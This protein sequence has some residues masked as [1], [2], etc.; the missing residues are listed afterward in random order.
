MSVSYLLL[1][2]F[3]DF[4]VLVGLQQGKYQ[5]SSLVG[6]SFL[7]FFS[8]VQ[9]VPESEQVFGDGFGVFVGRRGPLVYLDEFPPGAPRVDIDSCPFGVELDLGP[10]PGRQEMFQIILLLHHDILNFLAVDFQRQF[11]LKL[12]PLG[13]FHHILDLSGL[14]QGLLCVRYFLGVLLEIV[15]L[16]D[17]FYLSDRF[18]VLYGV[19]LMHLPTALQQVWQP[20]G[21]EVLVALVPEFQRT[22]LRYGQN[23]IDLD[24][25]LRN[26]GDLFVVHSLQNELGGV[27]FHQP[28][29]GQPD[30]LQLRV[31][32]HD[33]VWLFLERFDQ[34]VLFLL[35]CK[36]VQIYLLQIDIEDKPSLI[37]DYH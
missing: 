20:Q 21:E 33:I 23:R 14:A 6:L 29:L 19:D 25:E 17:I 28:R 35:I 10:D 26:D 13:H 31:V 15:G 7:G 1:R 18:L 2:G 34:K 27:Q 24:F 37:I 11:F 12:Q 32:L 9:R 5:L 22:V 8:H 16:N 3:V 30:T 4:L 36:L